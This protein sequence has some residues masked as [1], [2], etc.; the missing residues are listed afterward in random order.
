MNFQVVIRNCDFNSVFF[1]GSKLY[2][3]VILI[4]DQ[5]FPP[6]FTTHNL[7][8]VL[9]GWG[10]CQQTEVRQQRMMGAWASED[11]IR[12]SVGE[13][14]II[15]RVSLGEH[16]LMSLERNDIRGP[17]EVGS[18]HLES[19]LPDCIIFYCPEYPVCFLP[20]A[21]LHVSSSSYRSGRDL[22]L[23]PSITQVNEKILSFCHTVREKT[24]WIRGLVLFKLLVGFN[25][26]HVKVLQCLKLSSHATWTPDE[27]VIH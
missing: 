26:N 12:V 5:Y 15:I 21:L 14:I 25:F 1:P 19:R 22:S 13:G 18:G 7:Q 16:N 6:F 2:S 10:C 17:Q 24:G 23:G 27:K 4:Q 9:W 20:H 3:V 11:V 8:A